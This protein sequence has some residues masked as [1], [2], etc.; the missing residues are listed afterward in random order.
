[1]RTYYDIDLSDRSITKRELEGEA[2]VKAG[3]YFIAKTLLER[4]AATV[5]PLS[6]DNPL[7]FSAGPFAGTSFSNA[8][9]NFV[10]L[11]TL[12]RVEVVRGP[13]SSLYGSDALGGTVS[14]VTKDP[15]DYLKAGKDA[16]FGFR[17]GVDGEWDGLFSG[18]TAAFGGGPWLSVGEKPV[19]LITEPQVYLNPEAVE[20]AVKSGKATSRTQIE[21]VAA[22]AIAG[23]PGVYASYT[24]TQIMNNQIPPTDIASK[25][26]YGYH[27][28]LGGDV[29]MIMDPSFVPEAGYG[30][31]HGS[32]YVYDAH[33]PILISG[34]GIRSGVRTVRVT[35]TIDGVAYASDVTLRYSARAGRLVVAVRP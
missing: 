26:A 33:V 14:F 12:K 9:R 5:D 32:P 29:V 22:R 11:D 21:E 20:A 19:G 3:R 13:T 2:V 17:L 23:L 25:L 31:T 28:R 8:N 10:D 7:I 4:G 34:M 1:M 24:R 30:T 16:Y 18:A 6:P 27:A 15:S 35:I